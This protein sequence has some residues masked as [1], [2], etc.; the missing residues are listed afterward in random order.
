ML[1]SACVALG[2]QYSISTAAGGA[3]PASPAAALS[4]AAGLTQRVTV[5][6]AGNVYFSSGNSVFKQT[7]STVTQLAGNSRPGFS[8]DGGPAVAGQL[9]APEGLA[10]DSVGN[11]Y[12]ADSLNNRVRIVSPNGIINTFAGNG[13]TGYINNTGD[14]GAATDAQLSLPS[15]VS[16]D[17]KGD[18]FI[19]DTDHNQ[20][21]EVTPDGTISTV[22][23]DGYPSFYG[24]PT[25]TTNPDGTVTTNPSPATSA[26]LNHPEDVFV[27]TSGNLYV[28]DTENGAIRK[29]GTDGN[30][31]TVV[32]SPTTVGVGYSGDGGAAASAGLIEPF[33]VYIDGTGQIFIA[34]RA[35]GRIREVNNKGIINT[36]VG[37]G[38]L[39]FSGDGG[40]AAKAQL[41][42]PTGVALDSSG[43]VYIADDGNFRIRKDAGGTLNT[44]AGNGVYS[45]SGDGGKA[46][47]AQIYAPQG[48]AADAAGNFYIADT[49]NNVV[50]KVAANGVISTIA[51]NGTAG[52]TGDGGSATAA[53]LNAPQGVAVD[54]SGNL[55][56]A[57]TA[58][59]RVRKVTPGGAISTYAG[60]G[61]PGYAGDGGL[62]TSAQIYAPT[63]LAVD[64]AGNLYIA[65]FGNN[66]VREVTSGG[67]IS[68]LAGTG[69]QGYSGDGTPASH[70][71]LNGPQSVAVDKTGNVYIADQMNSRV[72][73]VTT[74]T[75]I[76]T[77]IAGTGVPGYSGDGG[78][79]TSAQLTPTGIAVDSAGNV[80]VSDGSARVRKLFPGGGIL[81]IGGN[82][83]Q[84]YAGDGGLATNANLNGP[85]GL[86]VDPQGDVFIADTNNNAVR[87]LVVAG[88][89][90]NIAAV[91]NGATNGSG[92]ISPGENVVLYGAG[93]GPATLAVNVPSSN[94]VYG[95]SI[96]GTSVYVNG[97][98]APILY[99]SAGQVSILI[100]FGVQGSQAQIYASYQGQ[101]STP[102]SV[103]VAQSTPGLFTL[104]FTGSGQ[105]AAVNQD[106]TGTI[107]GPS[108]PASSG[109]FVSLYGTGGG[110][111]VTPP[112]DGQIAQGPDNLAL[113]VSATIGGVTANVTYSG[114][115]P[116]SPY[117]IDQ[118]NVQ[119]PAGLSAG[120]QPVVVT[121]GGVQSQTGATLY[122]SG[123]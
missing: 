69:S 56:I 93:L 100:P 111:L 18:V 76:I 28:A 113:A 40:P 12:I 102:V 107:N 14:G 46:T 71:R 2:Q 122:V 80:Y 15:G 58:N 26:E 110:V 90:T 73:M 114:A 88:S 25:T 101:T 118:I 120:A 24:D 112:V 123:K 37:T 8:G 66:V 61:T 117:G 106:A 32:G 60:T 87:E 97:I 21:R 95:T 49:G 91:T 41:N 85:G 57:D 16:V 68:T 42:L 55:Y 51:G 6:K 3:P 74:S 22:A 70:S 48:V 78:P 64:S 96:G 1:G 17:S 104:S 82:G 89:G 45:Y 39:G 35:D 62:A 20:I 36:I 31:N 99:S 105:A 44:I 53:E 67:I 9:N 19:A 11:V 27:D 54:S 92:A 116:G 30:I 84:G 98:A 63:S 109:A 72:R 50:R 86:A 108:H 38:T 83:M 52:S 43:N 94:G 59:S 121:I 115:A 34:E 29:I 77:T 4:T 23:G 7:G 75:G 47:A 33:S 79:A 103:Q 81:T 65:D 10:V 5:D 119:I 13:Q